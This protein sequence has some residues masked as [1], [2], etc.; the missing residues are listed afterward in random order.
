M[1]R[2]LLLL[3]LAAAFA[4]APA[5]A[6]Q[7]LIV[8]TTSDLASLAE[9]V[10]GEEA[11][12]HA[13]S[14]GR[15]DPHMLQAKPSVIH[16]AR[17][18]DLWIR[19]G[20]DLEI[21]W[22]PPIL[23][24]SRNARIRPGTPGHLDASSFVQALDVP[25]GRITRAMGDVHPTGNPH[26][27]L[28]PLNGRLIAAGIA[29]RLAELRPERAAFFRE[30]AAAF[31]RQLD[32]RMFGAAWVEA[33][34]ADALWEQTSS[35]AIADLLERDTRAGGWIAALRPLRGKSILSYHRSWVYFARR[36]GIAIAG[37][38]EPKPGVPPTAAH[39]A[40]LAETVRTRHVA[41]ILQ[42]PFYSRKAADRLAGEAGIPVVV[43]ANAVGG[44]PE[45]TDYLALFDH[46]VQLI[47]AAP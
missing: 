25:E 28:D 37:E 12:V 29:E 14:S 40:E 39:L 1:K 10:A 16:L 9:A 46:L 36:F 3:A 18:A 6:D 4:A 7:L 43:A 20:L 5:R 22:E 2:L 35:G 34:G 13:I 11:V 19:V 24:G 44:Q 45:A 38:L 15:E 21:G 8:A 41:L 33:F 23:D 47:A 27:W 42:E 17:S 32:E 31:Q 30:R 26:Y